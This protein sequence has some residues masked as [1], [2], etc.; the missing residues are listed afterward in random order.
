MSKPFVG[1][2][3]G[4]GLGQALG[5]L[6]SGETHD[7]DTP[8]GKPSQPIVVTEVEGVRI[9]LLARHGQGHRHSPTFVPYRANIFAMKKL[10]VTH[11]LASA[12]SGSLKEEIA[13]RDLVVVDQAI[14]KTFRRPNTFFDELAVHTELASPFCPTLRGLMLAA[15]PK[16]KA[17]VHTQGTYV[18]MEGPGFSTRAE[19]E[20]HRSWGAEL[21]GMTLLPEAKLAREAELCY[22][23]VGL[24]TDY[25][26]W[27]P[28]EHE[29]DKL[30][31]LE[32]IIGNLKSA[33]AN[34]L[35]LLRATLP[36]VGQ[37]Q[38]G[39][40]ACASALAQAIWTDKNAIS[41][42]VKSK[43]APIIGKYVG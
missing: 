29:V 14:D 31:L 18:C 32:E 27:R 38:P 19:S 26:C 41:P 33:T 34:A 15:A 17:K 5:A 6:G 1:I 12:A 7:V 4:S 43:L 13:P 36:A 8:F 9:A 16:V 37:L 28:P 3:G 22:A 42:E 2:I 20:L 11:V 39:T 25:D 30:K 35:E 21:I 10:G 40:C 23:A 24:A